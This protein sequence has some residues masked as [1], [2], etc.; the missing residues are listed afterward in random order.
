MPQALAC[1]KY[2]IVEPQTG[3]VLQ[4]R[5]ASEPTPIASIQK[6][7]TALLVIEAGDLDR[8][9]EIVPDDI[10][11]MPIRADLR[12]G[13]AYARR[14]LLGAMLVG[15]ANDA[16]LALARDHA[17][18]LPAFA[19]AMTARAR[20]LGMADSTF[21]NPT[22]LPHEGQQST[23]QDAALLCAAADAVP[24][25]RTLV[26]QRHWQ[27]SHGAGDATRLDATNRLLRTMEACD[28]MKTGFTRA[29]GACLAATGSQ[30]VTRR[31]VVVL[32]STP[33][34]IWKDAG[35][36]LAASLGIESTIHGGALAAQD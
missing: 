6:L 4:A 29:S 15:S 12:P 1:G 19:E 13:G 32:G 3:S 35:G 24:L 9:V 25:V 5:N 8:P 20:A 23:A 26:A 27:V 16:A 7:M 18:S 10:A 28:G 36:L 17:G 33:D 30:G 14:D 2:V 34:D 22:G 31:L 21:R 11:C